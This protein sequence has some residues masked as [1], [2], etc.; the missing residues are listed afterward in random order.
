MEAVTP[1]FG[2]NFWDYVKEAEYQHMNKSTGEPQ[3]YRFSNPKS[4]KYPVMI[5]LF[6]RKM[7]SLQI[8]ED[9]RFTP[10]PIDDDI[11][12]LSAILLNE[13][14]YEFLKDGRIII[15]GV[16]ILAPTHIIPFKAKSTYL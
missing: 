6:S 5:E 15:D 10:L 12:S 11:S 7:E 1:E 2:K 3:F 4:K 16:P 8:D 13:A 14:Y 9:S